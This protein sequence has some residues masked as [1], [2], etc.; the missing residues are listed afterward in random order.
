MLKRTLRRFVLWSSRPP[1][2]AVYR[3]AYWLVIRFATLV[4]Q[5]YPSIRS[6]YLCR[7]CA[8][9]AITPGI[10]DIDF[11]IFLTN[12]S[13]EKPAIQKAFR[14]LGKMTGGLVDY[15]PNL[16]ATQEALEQ[17]WHSAPAWQYRYLEGQTT[18]QLLHGTDIFASLPPL[19]EEQRRTSCYVEMNRWWLL[20]AQ[21]MFEGKKAGSDTILHNV[22]CYKVVSELL[23]LQVELQAGIR[24]SRAEA[25]EKTNTAMAK[26]LTTLA[27]ERY[28]PFDN[29]LAEETFTFLITFFVDLWKSFTQSP[30]L[31]IAPN[32]TQSLDCPETEV[33]VGAKER[34]HLQAL[35]E[36]LTTHWGEKCHGIHR[37][38]SAFWDFDDLLWIVDID[39]NKLPTVQEIA[40]LTVL[41]HQNRKEL[42]QNIF[43]F[44]RIGEIAFPLTPSIPRDLHR[45]LLTPATMPDV[46]LQLGNNTVYWTDYTRW[47]LAEWQ[48]NQQWLEASPEK[49]QQLTLMEKSAA[50]GHIVYPLTRQ[51]L[52]REAQRTR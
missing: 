22:T 26:R 41:H 18:W 4:L 24:Q 51:A 8:K 7:G 50:K 1:L 23:N 19:T 13:Q 36:H 17:R 21:Q 39:Q 33:E 43:L 46:F 48:S 45:G 3:S 11:A 15:Y 37:V 10:S 2:L 47:Y 30:F 52:E 25:L 42:S 35:Q 49:K 28:L 38:K 44:L 6:L 34:E 12:D 32:L 40:A 27:A 5:R 16:V 9:N 20:F 31:D 14:V 29:Q